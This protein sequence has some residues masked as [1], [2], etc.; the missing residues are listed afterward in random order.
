MSTGND[1]DGAATPFGVVL[2]TFAEALNAGRVIG[3]MT[4]SGH[5]RLG[6][7]P[8]KTLSV[9]A[10][11]LRIAPL[12]RPGWGRSCLSYGPIINRPGLVF[13]VHLLNGHH[14]SQTYTLRRL[15]PRIGQWLR[16]SGVRPIRRRV[17]RLLF[18]DR[19]VSS[20]RRL[21]SWARATAAPDSPIARRF[22]PLAAKRQRNAGLRRIADNLAVGFFNRTTAV[23]LR[24]IDA[25][26]VVRSANNLHGELTVII[27]GRQVPVL[28][29]LGA[30]PLCL[31][32]IRRADS[33]LYAVSSLTDA[34]GMPGF[35]QFRPL[36]VGPPPVSAE[37]FPAVQQNVSGE[38]GFS[39]DSR[40]FSLA[41][42]VEPTLTTWFAG[43]HIADCFIG[44]GAITPT[45]TVVGLAWRPI[46]EPLRRSSNG[47]VGSMGDAAYIDPG[48]V[49]GLI[50]VTAANGPLGLALVWRARGDDDHWRLE[51]RATTFRLGRRRHGT[52]EWLAEGDLPPSVAALQV[53]DG[54]D[55]IRVVADET[56]IASLPVPADPATPTGFGLVSL[57]DGPLGLAR[58]EAHP[59]SVQIPT[60]LAS[61]LADDIRGIGDTVLIDD[62]F[63]AAEPGTLLE[64]RAAG[65]GLTWRRSLGTGRFVIGSPGRV[66]VESAPDRT[67]FTVPWPGAGLADIRAVIVPH[68]HDGAMA[69]AGLVSMQDDDNYLCVNLWFN[70]RS[71]GAASVSSFL[72]IDGHEDIY[73]AV[74]V[75]VERRIQWD[76]P[77]EVG[78]VFDGRL[79]QVSLDDEPV[80]WRRLDDVYADA[81]PMRIER[82]GL[83]A[84]WEWGLDTGSEFRR[85]L[86]K[87]PL[88]DAGRQPSGGRI[89]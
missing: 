3:S 31:V 53:L 29:R 20:W 17:M 21:G 65:P 8:E 57:V 24:E 56:L 27:N 87:A 9:D 82:V 68:R 49:T 39:V 7:D 6:S 5:R 33:T 74:W 28:G 54:D 12:E 4:Q 18:D 62:D 16:G 63:S 76:R 51:L 85:F 86:A 84:N 66:M 48:A 22:P 70:D 40:V 35:P 44:E 79:Y 14:A 26:F 64:G 81:E 13:A 80:M 34:R 23:S 45:P 71:D 89:T 52:D 42:T 75:N 73:D 32:T 59:R 72:T 88:A 10:G 37:L 47:A 67:A 11:G 58:I 55:E 50:H 60:G 61:G 30:L 78:L 69:R 36:A 19:R 77:V 83:L 1:E 25:G 41:A 43:A 15:V 46:G 38:I 2:D